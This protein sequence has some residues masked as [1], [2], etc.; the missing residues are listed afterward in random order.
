[1]RKGKTTETAPET[2]TPGNPTECS[3][4]ASVPRAGVDEEANSCAKGT[5]VK[6]LFVLLTT[7]SFHLRVR[8]FSPATIKATQDY[9]RPFLNVQDPLT[10]SKTDC[11]AYLAALASRCKP[12]TVAT[13]WRHLSGMFR[14]LH[15]EGD[16]DTNPMASIPKALAP[17]VE[18]PMATREQIL[19]LLK[20]CNGKDPM[21][22]RD[23]AIITIM[24][25]TGLRLTEIVNLTLDDI[26]EDF[27]LGVFGK[28]RKWRTVALGATSS[29]ALQRWLRVRQSTD[30]RIWTGRRGPLT[31]SG[32]RRML[33]RRSK[34]LGFHVHPHMLRHCFVDNWLRNGGAEVDLARLC[35]WTTTRMAERYARHRADERAI[36]AHKSV[37]P[38][39]SL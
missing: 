38:L 8:N 1:M 3:W 5:T 15:D 23:H 7:Y 26:S 37:A 16:I 10:A 33:Y 4:C 28:G 12:A 18:I 20:S 35:G 22:R 29:R 6:G 31:A 34:A 24:L 21:S 32:L 14:W 2:A 39:D 30:P 11:E 27:T 17:P 19:A 9:L 13:A 25:D 36:S